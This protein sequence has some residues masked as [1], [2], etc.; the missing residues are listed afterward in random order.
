MRLV[1]Q[2][3]NQSKRSLKQKGFIV[4]CLI[5]DFYTDYLKQ[6]GLF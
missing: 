6:I 5:V 2:D 1:K 4:K 3:E